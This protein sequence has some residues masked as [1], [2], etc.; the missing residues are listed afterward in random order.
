MLLPNILNNEIFK[1]KL[2]NL[3]GSGL[4]SVLDELQESIDESYLQQCEQQP[5]GE[6]LKT[7]NIARISSKQL[8]EKLKS[9]NLELTEE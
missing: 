8:L 1:R 2:A 7:L 4:D 9:S 3:K 6:M 5:D